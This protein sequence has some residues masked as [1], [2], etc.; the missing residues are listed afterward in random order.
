MFELRRHRE[1]HKV[2][3]DSVARSVQGAVTHCWV[4]GRRLQTWLLNDG[5]FCSACWNCSMLWL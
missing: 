4:G 5:W 2:A 3:P 1:D